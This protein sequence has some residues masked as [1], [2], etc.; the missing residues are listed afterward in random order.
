MKFKVNEDCIGCGLCASV[1]PAVFKMNDDGQAEAARGEVPKQYE[2]CATDAADS[3][4][5]AAI[6][7]E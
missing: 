6:E 1:C 4:P 2:A 3:C 5:V 7:K